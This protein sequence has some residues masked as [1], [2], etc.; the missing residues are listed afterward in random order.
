MTRVR[1]GSWKLGIQDPL[2]VGLLARSGRCRREPRPDRSTKS[3]FAPQSVDRETCT[4]Q[5]QPL[6]AELLGLSYLKDKLGKRSAQSRTG[7]LSPTMNSTGPD[8]PSPRALG[9]GM[10]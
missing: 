7:F 4:D 5:H 9:L 1:I 10:M 2:L 8:S 6:H 3:E